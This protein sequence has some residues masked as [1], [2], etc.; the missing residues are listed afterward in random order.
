MW[1]M[2]STPTTMRPVAATW[3]VARSRTSSPARGPSKPSQ[4]ENIFLKSLGG[5]PVF[6]KDVGKVEIVAR[7]PSGIYSKD[8]MDFSVEGIVIMRRGENPSQ[9][10]EKVKEAVADLNEKTLPAGVQV[11]PF[12]D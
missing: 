1:S 5:T 2:P 6:V 3:T 10:L 12:Y 7:P 8:D 11:V 4:I 9:V